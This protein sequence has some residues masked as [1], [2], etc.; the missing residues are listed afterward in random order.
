[1]P[2]YFI[3]IPDVST[4]VTKPVTDS[5]ISNVLASLG[6]ENA[7]IIYETEDQTEQ[8]NTGS[9]IGERR[10]QSYGNSDRITVTVDEERDRS[11]LE[12][13][14][15]YGLEIPFFH[16]SQFGI[17]ISPSSVQYDITVSIKRR[18]PSKAVVTN[19]YNEIQRKLDMG[20]DVFETQAEFYYKI[21]TP[22][23]NLLAECHRTIWF[24]DDEPGEPLIGYLKRCFTNNVTVLT[25]QGG[26]QTD[27]GVR[28]TLVRILTQINSDGPSVNKGDKLSTWECSFECKFSYMRPES[29]QMSYPVMMNNV[30]ISEEWWMNNLA[31]GLADYD[32]ATGGPLVEAGEDMIKPPYL[33]LP[34]FIPECEDPAIKVPGTGVGSIELAIIHLE[35]DWKL[36]PPNLL[37]NLLELGSTFSLSP[38]LIA[39]IQHAIAE[40]P[41][42]IHSIFK[43]V[44]FEDNYR[45]PDEKIAVAP[46]LNVYYNDYIHRSKIYRCYLILELDWS[47]LSDVGFDI[48]RF[49]PILVDIIL[50]EFRKPIKELIPIDLTK[51]KIPAKDLDK[52]IIETGKYDPN[53]GSH[54]DRGGNI[55]KM[56]TVTNSTLVS[57]RRNL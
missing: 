53:K 31:P 4:T 35:M 28:H 26:K 24:D 50:D 1:M 7:D 8:I 18:S 36:P 51:P 16:D 27:Y 54:Y 21:P 39:Y 12:R 46:D 34:V 2:N 25:N 23:L 29:V 32:G 17:T 47:D 48:I 38:E 10:K 45:V 30:L 20:R 52:I 33:R 13:G 55:R 5:V 11:R 49:H 57:Y 37:F 15:G 40:D 44:L 41:S 56:I 14:L 22:A 9:E 43:I 19:W 6:L 42:L 3:E